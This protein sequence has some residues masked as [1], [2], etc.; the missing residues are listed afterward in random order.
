MPNRLADETSP[1]LLQHAHQPVDWHPWGDEALRLA[2]ELDRPVFLSVGYS[3]CHWC[4]V[5]AHESFEDPEVAAFLNGHFICVKVDREERPE[6]DHVYMQAVVAM[7]GHGGWP[8]TVF[9]RP[10][11]QPFFGG[12]YFPPRPRGGLPG[13]LALI[14]GVDEAWRT[15]REFIDEVCAHLVGSL[16]EAARFQAPPEALDDGVF[17]RAV[18]ALRARFDA[19][20]GGFGDA[21]KFPPAMVLDF[22]LGEVARVGD[23][24]AL[25]MTTV[26]LRAM[27]RGGMHDLLGGGFCRY[28]TDRAWRI[29]HFEKMLTDNALLARVYLHAWQVTGDGFLR[30]VAESTLDF[31]RRELEHSEGGF[32]SSL[33][34]DGPGGEGRY[35]TWER[36]EVER[37]LG[38]DAALFCEAFGVIPEGNWEGTNI[39]YAAVPVAEQATTFGLSPVELEARLEDARRRLLAVRDERPR[40]GL[41][42]KR[43]AGANGLAMAACAEAGVALGRPDLIEAAVRCASFIRDRLLRPDGRVWRTCSPDGLA[44][45]AG[46]LEDYAYLADGLLALHQATLD[47]AWSEW[48]RELADLMLTHFS[49]HADGGFFDT[50]DDHERLPVRPR[51]LQDQAQPNPHAVAV[52]VLLRLASLEREVGYH[53]AARR[54]LESVSGLLG[55]FSQGFARWLTAAHLFLHP[56]EVTLEGDPVDPRVRSLADAARERWMPGLILIARGAQDENDTVVDDDPDDAPAVD[57]ADT[58]V[59]GEVPVAI[60][61]R[62]SACSLPVTTPAAL[63]ALLNPGAPT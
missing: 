28:A 21:P 35:Y 56:V 39:L 12:T 44:R 32:F 14:Q 11:G 58:T 59:A 23:P 54:A 37:A 15:R 48:A 2:R 63:A 33:D 8:M 5:M 24:A 10:D 36:A 16:R 27:A 46:V 49:D 26:T 45:H 61:C 6:L 29:P 55:R 60:V 51:E 62:D 7:N 3:A 57:G 31:L 19:A 22:L 53:E 17:P 47:P 40:P 1:Y 38:A 42:D 41:D 18:A 13:F 43:L 34:A 4:H 25:E 50:A 20:E 52:E 9:L 30:A